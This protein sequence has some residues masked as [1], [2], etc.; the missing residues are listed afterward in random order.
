[1]DQQA[2]RKDEAGFLAGGGEMGALM[3]RH[4]WSASPLGDPA[5]WPQSLRSVVGLMLES[6]FPMFVAWGPELAFLYNDGYRPIFGAKH[7]R[8]LGLP[9]RE[10]WS[11]IWADIEP[12]VAKALA[13][14]ATFHENL[15]LVMERN[16]YPEDTWY[17]FSYSPVRDE[18]GAVA[19]M[20][21]ACTETTG[22]VLAERGLRDSEENYRYAS[23]LSPQTVWT[24][25]PDGQLDHVGV[26]WREWTGTSGL[27]SGWGDAVHPDDLARSVDA[28]TRSV[29]TGEPYDIRH[30]ARLRDGSFRWMH[31]R[32]FPRRDEAGAIVRWYGTTQDIHAARTAEEALRES[33]ARFRNM[34]DHAPVMMWVTDPDGHCTWLNRRW[35]E[36]TGQAEAEALGLGWTKATHPDDQKAAEEAFL[37]ANAARAPFQIEYRLRRADGAYRWAIDAASPRFGPDGAFLGYI[38]SVIDIGDRREAEDALRESNDRLALATEAT[39][40]GIWDY[41]PV[42]GAL[43]WEERCKALFG[44]PPS[45]EVDYGT[46]LAGLHPDDREATDAAVQRALAPDGPGEYDIEYRTVGIED[47]VERW[48]AAKGKAFFEGSG[49]ARRAVR[50]VGTVRDIGERKAATQ[51]LR[52]SEARLRGVLEGMGEGFALL[53]RGFRIREINAEG[54]RLETRPREAIV[55]KTHWE[56]YPGSEEGEIGRLYKRAMAERAPVGLEH[57]YTWQDGRDAWLD[58]RAY[59]TGDGLAVFYR[60]ITERKRAEARRLALVELSD[61]I[62]DIDDPAELSFAAAEILGRTLGVSRAGYGTI[63]TAAET[64]TIERDWNA[65]GIESLAG[66][67]RF[68]D[69]GS[70]I[71]DL[72]RGETVVFADAEKDPRTAATADALKAISAQ[73]VV[74][75]PVT[76]QGGFVALLY[77]NHATAREWPEEE[78]ALVREVAE[79]T[80]TAVE[81]RRAEQALRQSEAGARKL[82][83]QQS[84]TLGQLAEG[85]IVTDAAGRITLINEAAARLHGV[86][87]LDVAPDAYSA[88]YSLLTE[89]GRPYPSL[90]LP[91]ARAVRGETVLEARWRIRRPD[92]S[93]VL[94]VGNARPVLDGAGRQVGAVLTIRDDTARRAAEE[95]LERLNR[96]LEETVAERTRELDRVWRNSRDLLVV[97]GA[98]G[99]FRAVNPAWTAILGHE[100]DEVV[101]HSFLDFIWPDDAGATRDALDTAASKSDLTDFENRYRHKDGTPR[102]ISWR[103]S[104]EGD[105]VY[106]YGRDVTAEKEQAA[107]LRLAEEQLRQSQKMEAVGQLTGGIAHDFNNLLAGITGSLEMLGVRVAQGRVAEIDRYVNAAQ[108]A[109]KRAAALTHRLLAFSRRQTLDPKPVDLNRLVA[110]M[111]DLV[112][113]TVGPEVAVEVVAAGGLWTTLADPN[114]LE[115]ALLNLCINARDAMPDGGKLTIETANRWLDARAARERDLAPGQYVSLCVSDTGTGMAPEVAR[116]AFDPFFTTKPIGMGTGLGLSMIYGFVRQSGGQARIYSEPGQGATVCLYL[117]R[118]FDAD[119]GGAEAAAGEARPPPRAGRG[120]TVLVVDDE[121]TVRML[122]GEVLEDLGYAVIE[123][124]DGPSGLRALRSADRLDLLITDVGLPG[125]MNGRQLADAAREARPGLKVLFITGYAENAVLNHGHLGPGMQVLTKPFSMESLAGRIKDMTAGT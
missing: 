112:R 83:A 30:R 81:R 27:G 5:A 2:E 99:V 95:A 98:D 67:L 29:A 47:R 9:F 105:L 88:A 102:W 17:T 87:R 54:M 1:M 97:V 12:L 22:Q 21:C 6:K 43:R 78:L 19:G 41:D 44:L 121:P 24:A 72:K 36:F 71:E 57:R 52:E 108:G 66:V 51:A 10:V 124:A 61:R 100:P 91:L 38:G 103:T 68:R 39:G 76:E 69:Y 70:Y 48:V 120:E 77:L 65:P 45:A 49:A 116:R 26:R 73:A 104:A 122:I 50:F 118:H 13:G 111:E 86:R 74:N 53:D 96:S 59:P 46:F 8:A 56:A 119:G 33:E 20:F 117:P 3:R 16:G 94:A 11:E 115:N 60:D 125:G 113:R 31:S 25:R 40:A 23:D 7:P 101:G 55:G 82:A 15:H 92:G 90:D 35:Y 58:M 84:A 107:A 4:D 85:V 110:G 106:A 42:S 93:E 32:A 34:A 75:M 14:E 64:I 123:A 62:R 37:S 114:Q 63:D 109:A 18:S 79:R 80:R 89:D 28:W